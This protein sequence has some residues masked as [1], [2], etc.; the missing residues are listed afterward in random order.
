MI[1]VNRNSILTLVLSALV[2][3]QT[4][5]GVQLEKLSRGVVA[6]KNGNSTFVSW[7]VLATDSDDVTFD[8]LRDGQLIQSNLN[9]SNVTITGGS[10]KSLYQVVVKE[11]GEAVD[12]SAAVTCWSNIYKH[13]R[14]DR[15]ISQ[16]DYHYFPYDGSVGTFQF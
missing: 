3:V 10:D 2:S 16:P 7:R 9:V 6:I 4:I 1:N 8:L 12:T 14:L 11:K 13:I 5:A 15:P